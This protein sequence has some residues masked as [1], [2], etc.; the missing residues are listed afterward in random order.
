MCH[1]RSFVLLLVCFLLSGLAGLI[2]QTAWTQQFAFVFGASELAVAAVLAAYMAGLALGAAAAGRWQARIHRPVRVYALLELGI[3][4]SALAV[5]FALQLAGQLQA[6]LLGGSEL[7]AGTGGLTSAVFYLGVSFAVLLVPTSFM[8]ATLPLLARY[9]VHRDAQIGARVGVLYTVN[10][11]GAAL[12]ALLTAFVLLPQLG[13]TQT[14]L[15]AVGVNSVVFLLVLLL[16]RSDSVAETQTEERL[17]ACL[18]SPPTRRSSTAWILPAMLISG[19]V[20]FTYEIVWTRLLTHLLGGSVYAFSTMLATFLAGL[21]LGAGVAARFAGNGQQARRGFV[22]AQLGSAVGAVGA[23]YSV[24]ALPDLIGS[25]AGGTGFLAV[26]AA[27]SACTLLPGA[28]CI[29]ATFPFAV[30][31]YAGGPDE[32]APASARVFAWNTVGAIIGAIGAGFFV[33]PALRF[34]GTVSLAAALSLSLAIGAAVLGRPRLPGF[35]TVGG[36]LLLGLAVLPLSPPWTILRYGALQGNIAIGEV[37]SY[38][39]GRSA[40]VVI[41]EQPRSWRLLTNGLP[42]SLFSRPGTRLGSP[43]TARWLSL[44]PVA[45]RSGVRS[46][47]LIGLG[48]GVSLE[49]VPRTVETIHVVELEPEVVRANQLMADRRQIDPL[50]DPRL[51]LHINDARSALT[52]GAQ[53]F[54]AIISQPSHP[55][56]AGASHLFTREFFS[57]VRNRLQ[58]DGVF[59]QWM[60][61]RFV[62]EALLRSLLVTLLTVFPHVEVYEP[63]PGGSLLF[64]ASAAPLQLETQAGL[65]L[66]SDPAAWQAGGVNVPEDLLVARVLDEKGVQALAA[67][68]QINTD[69]HN[70]LQFGSPKALARPL[71]RP[72]A[73][74]LFAAHDPL[75]SSSQPFDR[76]YASRALIARGDVNR[77]RRL[78]GTIIDPVSRQTTLGLVQLAAG[79]RSAG[80]QTLWTAFQINPRASLPLQG[81]LS[82]AQ[83][84]ILNGR[85]PQRLTMA[86]QSDPEAVVLEGW[87]RARTDNWRAVR[88]LESRLAA[89]TPYDP[90]FAPAL[91]LRADWRVRTGDAQ[92]AAEAMSLLTPLLMFNPSIQDLLLQVRASLIAGDNMAG[93]AGLLDLSAML[94]QRRQRLRPAVVQHSIQQLAQLLAQLPV[95]VH[96]DPRY[97]VMR[98]RLKTLLE[99]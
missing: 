66:D 22:L 97:G 71:G 35:A 80:R 84:A 67:E 6:V 86:I 43:T 2:Y 81:L 73:L 68:A 32:A 65:A 58:P 56:T 92:H 59:V 69:G 95:T 18:L 60:G 89:L 98:E 12:G 47:L 48:A 7:S 90:L 26:G 91:R 11:A 70:L 55:W 74:R 79:R 3:A 24:E 76:A 75:L 42:E 77:A 87:R 19:V 14:V 39:V 5:P 25:S 44:L 57:L 9:A 45:V 27:L 61:L 64:A 29:G 15:V 40:T 53:R 30:R 50:T 17:A 99:E 38:G 20:S 4:V 51:Q 16:V 72:K 10:T 54:D 83:F 37:V 78:A 1:I 8:G 36:L 88:R 52:L 41:V 63:P 46:M 94:T 96:D 62:D 13:L 34:V 21:A 85:E 23:F 82:R 28:V 93:L 49:H 33:L 31:L